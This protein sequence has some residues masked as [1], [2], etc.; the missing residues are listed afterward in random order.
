[1]YSEYLNLF[2][3]SNFD[4]RIYLGYNGIMAD[5]DGIFSDIAEVAG[6]VG[7]AVAGELKKLGQS[8]TSQVTGGAG[9]ASN[10]AGAAKSAAGMKTGADSGGPSFLDELKKFGQT[11]T[12]QVTGHEPA[13]SD[14]QVKAMAKS[15]EAFS[16][17]ESALVAA[18]IKQIYADYAA[19]RAQEEKQEEV[20][21]KQQE[22]MKEEQKKEIKKEETNVAIQKTRPEIKNYGAE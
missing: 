16:K 6:D 4:I 5:G 15:D 20:V 14:K 2:R 8:A 7:G 12:S 1:L 9:A 21:V 11:A 22:E 19:K 18:K 3:V 10:L 17:Q 13:I